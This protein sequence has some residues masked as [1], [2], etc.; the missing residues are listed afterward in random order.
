VLWESFNMTSDIDHWCINASVYKDRVEEVH[1]LS[2]PKRNVRRMQQIKTW[3]VAQLIGRG[4]IGD[5]RLE[6]N[7]EDG[8]VR[9]VKRMVM[10]NQNLSNSEFEKELEALLEFSKPKVRLIISQPR[11]IYFYDR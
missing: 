9:A 11:T 3:H 7:R 8:E 6:I 4:G 2:D 1:Y 5:V 10:L